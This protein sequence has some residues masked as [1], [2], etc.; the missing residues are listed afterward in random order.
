MKGFGEVRILGIT[1]MLVCLLGKCAM[2]EERPMIL[3]GGTR[4]ALA[5]CRGT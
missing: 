4:E 2:A 3:V 1:L 5:V